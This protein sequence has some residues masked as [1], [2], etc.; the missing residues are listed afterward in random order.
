MP[1]MSVI[2]D[3]AENKSSRRAFLSGKSAADALGDALAGPPP[4][5]PPPS[6]VVGVQPGSHLLSVSREA[7]ACL[8]EVVFDATNRDATEAA[9]TALELVAALEGQLTIYRD[10]SEIADINR[11]AFDQPVAVESGLFALLQRAIKLSEET[12]GAF[13]IT[14]GRLSK[15]WGFFRRQ[16]QMP[17]ETDV[18]E[19]LATVGSQ[20]LELDDA[21]KT[22]RFQKTGLELNL[23]A[24]GKGYALDRAADLLIASGLSDFLIH[25]GNSSVLARGTRMK[26]EGGR[27]SNEVK[28]RDS[29][30]S[31]QP[32]AFAWSIALRHPLKPDIRLAEFFLHDQA[33]GTSGS[34]TQFFHHQGKRYGHI[35]DP[36][37]GWPAEKVLSATVIAPNAEQADALSTAFYVAGLE[38]AQNYCQQHPEISALVTTQSGPAGIE[39]HPVNLSPDSWRRL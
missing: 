10:T 19:A 23:G 27:M 16:G 17:A 18:A 38:L 21:T 30:F 31:L 39:L 12:N 33:L 25:G 14:A 24:I 20:Y 7:M 11:R 37:S 3:M 2:N 35:I 32:S 26:D 1:T 6:S 34:G 15:T 13:D 29:A 36:R 5:L 22:V 8:F 9:V 4:P 28:I